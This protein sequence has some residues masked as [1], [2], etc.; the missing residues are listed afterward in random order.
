MVVPLNKLD[1]DVLAKHYYP[2]L[3]ERAQSMC[4][5]NHTTAEEAVQDTIIAA[6]TKR[7][8]VRGSFES[9]ISGILRNKVRDSRRLNR[10]KNYMMEPLPKFYDKATTESSS[11]SEIYERILNEIDSLPNNYR[12]VCKLTLVDDMEQQDIAD[13]LNIPLGTVQSRQGRS[14]SILQNKLKDLRNG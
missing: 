5:G 12:D 6:W 4:Y 7:D 8:Q 1:F 2:F 10:S 14:K 13:K 3:M 11:D 9:W